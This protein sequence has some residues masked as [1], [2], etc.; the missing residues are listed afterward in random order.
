MVLGIV[1]A[2]D[3][4]RSLFVFESGVFALHRARPLLWFGL[5]PLGGNHNALGELMLLAAPLTLAWSALQATTF[6]RD[7]ARA[8]AALMVLVTLLTFARSAWIALGVEILFLAATIWKED[9]RRHK[10]KLY[11]AGLLL[12]PVAAYMVWFSL[13]PG[14]QSST[15]ARATLTG[16][17]LSLFEGNPL[18]GV[19]AGTFIE[20][21]GRTWAYTI[22]F[23]QPIES[24]GI[25]QKLGAE[26]GLLGLL[27]MAWVVWAFAGFA[28]AGWR[29]ARRRASNLELYALLLAAVIGAG[30][31]QL[32][33]TTYWTPRLWLPVGLLLAS[34][35]IMRDETPKQDPDFLTTSHGA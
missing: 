4:I 13:T 23:G 16:I 29:T 14:V 20:R 24:H 25:L 18:T 12:A 21:V 11:L 2:L 33:D 9:V 30:V 6:R 34:M 1:F 26:T 3:G 15:D 7:L 19:G 10:R 28:R 22:E 27:A 17:A 5:N 8:A 32:F 31:Y 35:R